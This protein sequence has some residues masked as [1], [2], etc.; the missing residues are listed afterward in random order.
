MLFAINNLKE[1]AGSYYKGKGGFSRR[2]RGRGGY[3]SKRGKRAF[4]LTGNNRLYPDS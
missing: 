1:G 2:G 3:Y 4:I